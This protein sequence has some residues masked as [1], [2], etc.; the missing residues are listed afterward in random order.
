MQTAG[1]TKWP[2]TLSSLKRTADLEALHTFNMTQKELLTYPTG[3]NQVSIQVF[4]MKGERKGKKRGV[5][6]EKTTVNNTPPR[7]A[8]LS[9]LCKK[10]QSIKPL[11]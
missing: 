11:N 3:L 2:G 9:H 4:Q 8:T 5:G 10:N 1:Y 6:E 7:N